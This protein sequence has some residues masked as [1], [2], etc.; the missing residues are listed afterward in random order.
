MFGARDPWSFPKAVRDSFLPI[1]CNVE[2]KFLFHPWNARFE[3]L[4]AE[5]AKWLQAFLYLFL[6]NHREKSKPGTVLRMPALLRFQKYAKDLR[7][8]ESSGLVQILFDSPL[9]SIE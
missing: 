3:R 4:L 7:Q 8:S 5:N 6:S 2:Y 9:R 1:L